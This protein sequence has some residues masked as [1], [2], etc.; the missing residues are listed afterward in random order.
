MVRILVDQ[1]I[2][3]LDKNRPPVLPLPRDCIGKQSSIQNIRLTK[4]KLIKL[5]QEKKLKHKGLYTVLTMR[6]EPGNEKMRRDLLKKM[7]EDSPFLDEYD[8]LNQK[9]EEKR[10]K[11]NKTK[12][13]KK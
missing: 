3:A 9:R 4:G 6:Y 8:P 1:H 7:D 11:F 10:R 13:N 12:K 5:I 2:E